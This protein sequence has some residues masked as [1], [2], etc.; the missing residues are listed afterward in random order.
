MS[1]RLVRHDEESR[2]GL[3]NLGDPIGGTSGQI[4]A[5][6]VP[7]GSRHMKVRAIS[8]L[9]LFFASYLGHYTLLGSLSDLVPGCLG[10]SEEYRDLFRMVAA[11]LWTTCGCA[12]G[13]ELSGAAAH[14]KR[15]AVDHVFSVLC[16]LLALPTVNHI[17]SAQVLLWPKSYIRLALGMIPAGFA[18]M[19]GWYAA[20]SWVYLASMLDGTLVKLRQAAARQSDNE[21][22]KRDRDESFC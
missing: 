11:L 15:H 22:N 12:M 1:G 17:V 3:C 13:F 18:F 4:P 16:Y 21:G 10:V 6:R 7:A 20:T 2:S 14:E 8:T 5:L 9:L 19:S